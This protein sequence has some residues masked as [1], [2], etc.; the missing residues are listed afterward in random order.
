MAASAMPAIEKV[1]ATASSSSTGRRPVPRPSIDGAEVVA[2]GS[3]TPGSD[4]SRARAE[5]AASRRSSVA[6]AR[7]WRWARWRMRR[8]W[9]PMRR[10]GRRGLLAHREHGEEE[11]AGEKARH[12]RGGRGGGAPALAAACA[13]VERDVLGEG[14][15]RQAGHAMARQ[16][17]E[18]ARHALDAAG[19]IGAGAARG[20]RA[21]A[22]SVALIAPRVVGRDG[23]AAREEKRPDRLA[24]TRAPTALAAPPISRRLRGRAARPRS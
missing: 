10:G 24:E 6:G 23:P 18:P 5:R 9:R 2:A 12:R 4:R 14:G 22:R 15:G 16:V 3:R 20:G 1:A 8:R 13:P 19:E 11:P 21:S 17:V 7:P